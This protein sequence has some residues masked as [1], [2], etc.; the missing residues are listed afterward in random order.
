[1]VELSD[2]ISVGVVGLGYVGLPLALSFERAG[3]DVVGVDADPGKIDRLREGTTTVD[4]VSDEELAA[5]VDAGFEPTHDFETLGEVDAVLIAVPTPLSDGNPE[6]HFVNAAAQSVAE[7]IRPGTLVVLESTIYP[8][9]T[10]ETVVKAL[11]RKGFAPGDDAFVAFSPERISPGSGHEL[12]EIPKVVGGLTDA[13]TER[14]ADLYGSVFEEVVRVDSPREAEF[15]KMIENT[16]RA[17]NISY[18]NELAKIGHRLDVDVWES[19]DAAATKPFG[20]MPFYPGPGVGG[21]CIPVDPRFLAWQ[22][23]LKGAETPLIDM[24]LRVDDHMP[25]YVVSRVE[26]SLESRGVAL[27]DAEILVLGMTYKPDV[28]D[29]R[30]SPSIEMFELFDAKA[31]AVEFHD[32][33]VDE[34]TIDHERRNSVDPTDLE[35]YDCVVLATDHSSFDLDRIVESSSLVFDARNAIDRA[36]DHV[37]T[38]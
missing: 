11:E 36:D 28:S 15:S 10:E 8:G 21:H 5:A 23:S 4:D 31:R 24:A 20:F 12:T 29:V 34:V 38:L 18:V 26:D 2:T 3:F 9:G 16:F 37:V 6:L 33:L 22:A 14:A 13:C 30:E 19:I 32:P 27:E 17:V 7:V 1:M 35:T 25:A